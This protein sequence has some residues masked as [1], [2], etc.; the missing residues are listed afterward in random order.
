MDLEINQVKCNGSS[1]FN[2]VKIDDRRYI[3]EAMHRREI[4]IERG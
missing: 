2:E 3:C 1:Q 4:K